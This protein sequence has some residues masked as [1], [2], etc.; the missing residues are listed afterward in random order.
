MEISVY[1][2]NISQ[3]FNRLCKICEKVDILEKKTAT[4]KLETEKKDA[5]R[6]CNTNHDS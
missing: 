5:N 6:R 1:E 4:K 3:A 2:N